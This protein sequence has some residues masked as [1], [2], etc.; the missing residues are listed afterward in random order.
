MCDNFRL[1]HVELLIHAFKEEKDKY[2]QSIEYSSIV[3]F[4]SY[5]ENNFN[6]S[7]HPQIKKI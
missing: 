1:P 4:D 5:I 7:I 6:D 2:L 3:R